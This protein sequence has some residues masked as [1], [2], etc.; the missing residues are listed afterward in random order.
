MSSIQT[1]VLKYN[2]DFFLQKNKIFN[3]G[4]HALIGFEWNYVNI[5]H[6]AKKIMNLFIYKSFHLNKYC[7]N[8]KT[9]SIIGPTKNLPLQDWHKKILFFLIGIKEN[10]IRYI[11]SK[12]FEFEC[13]ENLF[14]S[15][16]SNYLFTGP[17]ES[18]FFRKV[19]Q[20]KLSL[21][22]ERKMVVL[23]KRKRNRVI[24][25]ENELE[26]HIKTKYNLSEFQIVYN[27]DL[28]FEQQASIFSKTKFLI[29]VHGA[30]V[31]NIIF[32]PP[33]AVVL[34]I[35]PPYFFNEVYH[36]IALNSGLN[37]FR[38]SSTD[39]SLNE[40]KNIDKN[41][42]ECFRNNRCRQFRRD[43]NFTINIQKFSIIFEQILEIV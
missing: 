3:S 41:V 34:E 30:G 39:Y 9:L 1:E 27:E 25:N 6:W 16:S 17:K 12:T 7:Q 24:L 19:I 38:F 21:K 29:T 37:Y 42:R 13:Y 4:C 32:M 40:S 8:F 33:T 26:A 15:G 5:Y 31:T 18:I 28:N 2:D 20:Q 10:E 43:K 35:F 14:V 11:K 23:L 22:F 36:R